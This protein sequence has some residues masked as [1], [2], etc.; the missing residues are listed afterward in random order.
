MCHSF[1]LPT[2]PPDL[3]VQTEWSW[4]FAAFGLKS[5]VLSARRACC[6]PRGASP[7][8][9]MSSSAPASAL[10]TNAQRKAGSQMDQRNKGQT[11]TDRHTRT[12]THTQ[13]H[14]QRHRQTDRHRHTDRQTDT[15]R[16]TD[17]QTHTQTH[18]HRHTH[19]LTHR[20]TQTHTDTHRHTQTHTHR[21]QGGEHPSTANLVLR[22][23]RRLN[24]PKLDRPSGCCRNAC[25]IPICSVK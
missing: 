10:C 1:C 20:H 25:S 21:Q 6:V 13:T 5:A 22:T 24:E 23:A 4:P 12:R 15:H 18:R 2:T 3:S 17:T 7:I 9:A 14:I 8:C 19:M 11:Q 16:H